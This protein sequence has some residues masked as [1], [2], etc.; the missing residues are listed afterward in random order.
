ML[1]RPGATGAVHKAQ[2]LKFKLVHDPVDFLRL[3]AKQD[4]HAARKK[5]NVVLAA[6]S[7]SDFGI[8]AQMAAAFTGAFYTTPTAFAQQDSPEGIQYTEKL[9]SS[10]RSYYHVAVTAALE[11]ELPTLPHLLRALSQAPSGCV[12]Y[13]M[14]PK[15]LCK[16]FT[17]HVKGTPRLVQRA[18]VLCRPGE[19]ENTE[20]KKACKPIYNSPK[21][22]LLRFDASRSARCPGS[23]AAA[24]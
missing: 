23:K 3:E 10:K 19:A 12:V 6:T 24:A 9:R 15:K 20:V 4:S 22:W 1:V 13:Y 17:K 21:N 18:C 11:K 2:R 16:F 14:S 5:G 7:D 8:A